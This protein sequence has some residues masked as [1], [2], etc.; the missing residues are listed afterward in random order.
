MIQT[1]AESSISLKQVPMMNEFIP[2]II[3]GMTTKYRIFDD[4]TIRITVTQITP[5]ENPL[6]YRELIEQ[7]VGR[8]AIPLTFCND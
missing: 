4:A 5:T 3:L 2:H 8:Y 7:H 6:N 1:Y